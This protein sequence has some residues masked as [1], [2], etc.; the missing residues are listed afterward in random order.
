LRKGKAKSHSL[1]RGLDYLMIGAIGE[2]EGRIAEKSLR[3]RG[4]QR[5]QRVLTARRST[6]T[7]RGTEAREQKESREDNKSRTGG[8]PYGRGRGRD[9]VSPE[10]KRFLEGKGNTLKFVLKKPSWEKKWEAGLDKVGAM[11]SKPADKRKSTEKRKG[12]AAG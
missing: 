7:G 1:R 2:G 6:K 10:E 11:F 3:K 12:K 8:L 5:K 4:V 9:F